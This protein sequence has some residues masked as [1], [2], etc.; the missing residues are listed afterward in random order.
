MNFCKDCK[1]A[2]PREYP[3]GPDYWTCSSP[4]AFDIT[5]PVTGEHRRSFKF[6]DILRN[7]SDSTVS[8]LWW[9]KTFPPHRRCGKEGHWFEPKE[10]A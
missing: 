4:K 3:H 6:C 7:G 1:H 8:F 9:K 5:D 2:D 10:Q